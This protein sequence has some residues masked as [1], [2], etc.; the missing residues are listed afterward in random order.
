MPP[1]AHAGGVDRTNLRAQGEPLVAFVHGGGHVDS[2]DDEPI[3]LGID[4][5]VGKS[6][7]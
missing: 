4:G 3:D 5:D 1:L 2:V 7:M 6:G